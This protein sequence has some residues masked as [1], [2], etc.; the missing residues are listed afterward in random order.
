MGRKPHEKGRLLPRDDRSLPTAETSFLKLRRR[1]QKH[2]TDY[3]VTWRTVLTVVS[4]GLLTATIVQPRH[5]LSDITQI[6]SSAADVLF[7]RGRPFA[8][9][10]RSTSSE[11]HR[12]LDKQFKAMPEE[13]R[14]ATLDRVQQSP[15][16]RFES[17]TWYSEKYHV[18]QRGLR[19]TWARVLSGFMAN[20][21]VSQ[22]CSQTIIQHF[23]DDENNMHA[24]SVLVTIAG[25]NVTFDK[26]YGDRKH[27]RYNSMVHSIT[28]LLQ[29]Q[30]HK[31][32]DMT[33]IVML[34]DGHKPFV[35][36]FG[37]ARHWESWHNMIP[38]PMGNDRGQA[39]GWGSTI[40]GWD[41]YISDNVKRTSDFYPWKS[42]INRAF[43]RGSLMMQTYKLGTCN[44]GGRRK[45]ARASSWSEVARGVMYEK[46]QARPDLFDIS[47]TKHGYKENIGPDQFKNAPTIGES[48]K[49]TEAQKYKYV[50]NVGSNQDWAERLRLHFYMNSAI[51]MH[52]AETKEFFYPL[53]VPWKHVI[54]AN[55]MFNDLVRNV[56]W[57]T[58]HDADAEK[59][60]ENMNNFA[61]VYLSERSMSIYW[62]TA[63]TEYAA[64]QR[65]ADIAHGKQKERLQGF[66]GL[67][68]KR[69]APLLRPKSEL[70]PRK[71]T[72]QAITDLDR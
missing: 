22:F 38:V 25:G 68:R 24:T 3:N 61:E 1:A 8:A 69:M 42:K 26:R 51:V 67:G 52:M 31:I 49:F 56:K 5:S 36:T 27:S 19:P 32:P 10:G 7:Q 11:H 39:E 55:L 54:P 23:E 57:A 43:F 20:I 18:L 30:N 46:A 6:A 33:F 48:V 4:F 58:K 12:T 13:Q 15:A 62:Q 65:E 71:T 72:K 50:L 44:K 35:P 40:S 17:S 2:A 64:R 70:D 9:N 45:C 59:I 37:A 66:L 34:N 41:K 47:F 28:M 53:I 21:H 63:L 29:A 14:K 16:H 60:V